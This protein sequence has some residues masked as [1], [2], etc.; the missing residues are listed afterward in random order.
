MRR[1][2]GTEFSAEVSLSAV[3][4]KGQWYSIGI[5]RDISERKRAD[6]ALRESEEKHRQF[7]ENAPL[8]YQSLDA[9]GN[10]LDVN[11]EWLKVLG[12]SK[13]AVRGA[14]ELFCGSITAWG[15]PTDLARQATVSSK[16]LFGNPRPVEISAAD[17]TWQTATVTI[18]VI[19][20]FLTD[21]FPCTSTCNGVNFLWW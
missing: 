21:F 13:E 14:P 18:V 3:K 4:I 10:F 15:A 7:Y 12:Y 8:G 5:M 1:R 2:D 19:L 17:C 20:H 9:S 6:K 16:I 11:K